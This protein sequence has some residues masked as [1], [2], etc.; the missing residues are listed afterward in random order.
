MVAGVSADVLV[1]EQAVL[2]LIMALRRYS[3]LTSLIAVAVPTM[4]A[5]DGITI[6]V[7]A[8]DRRTEVAIQRGYSVATVACVKELVSEIVAYGGVPTGWTLTFDSDE[9]VHFR[10][11]ENPDYR[12]RCIEGRQITTENGRDEVYQIYDENGEPTIEEP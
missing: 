3:S 11:K 10:S 1:S 8:F 2:L 5:A 6:K 7:E 4:A 12:H 9:A